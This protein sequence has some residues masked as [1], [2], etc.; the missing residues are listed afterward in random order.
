MQGKPRGHQSGPLVDRPAHQDAERTTTARVTRPPAHVGGT[1]IRSG[2]AA[3]RWAANQVDHPNPP[4]PH[5][6]WYRRC[7]VFVR[8]C[9]DVDSKYESA[10][11][12]YYATEFKRGDRST[13][14]AGV[15]VWWTNGGAGHVALS[16]GNGFCYSTDILREGK[17]DKVRIG[18]ITERW[19]QHYRGW[20]EDINGVRVWTDESP[21]PPSSVSLSN[22]RDAAR[23]DKSRPDGHGCHEVDVRIVERALRKERLLDPSYAR[24]GYAGTAF[25][26]AYAKWQE[27]VVPPPYDG[28]PGRESLTK[29]GARHGFRVLD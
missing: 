17:V 23:R 4:S 20:S 24:D 16:A 28:I 11:L 15:P 6:T 27:R 25:L 12:A 5:E 7:L 22:V 3:L 21:Q 2:A 26:A 13:P 8:S 10:E 29:L 18:F 9:F 19:G 1:D 14:P